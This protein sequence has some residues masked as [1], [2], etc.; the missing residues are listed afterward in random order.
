MEAYLLAKEKA[1]VKMNGEAFCK[2]EEEY[3]WKHNIKLIYTKS[4]ISKNLKKPTR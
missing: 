3:A 2:A 4:E 1:N